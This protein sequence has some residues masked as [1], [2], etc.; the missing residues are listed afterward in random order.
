MQLLVS[1][2]TRAGSTKGEAGGHGSG[3]NE[4]TECVTAHCFDAL[5][6]LVCMVMDTGMI[7]RWHAQ[8]DKVPGLVDLP[9]KRPLGLVEMLMQALL[10]IQIQI[11]S[12]VWDDNQMIG[13]FQ[14]GCTRHMG[15]E[16]T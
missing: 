3:G 14:V 8:G 7:P 13:N 11:V 4:V 15:C 9:N 6:V 5:R 2:H 1:A 16:A 10:G 12:G